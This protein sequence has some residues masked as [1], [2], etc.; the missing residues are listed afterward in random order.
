[1]MF[2]LELTVELST[3]SVLDHLTLQDVIIHEPCSM[4]WKSCT[5]KC[6]NANCLKW[7]S[8]IIGMRHNL[9]SHMKTA[10][11]KL[12]FSRYCT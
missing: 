3:E 8:H 6:D 9:V 5:A 4:Q 2:Y 1:M 7:L 10:Y 12:L 11:G